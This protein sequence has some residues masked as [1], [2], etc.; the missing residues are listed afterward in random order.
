MTMMIRVS[1]IT[2]ALGLGLSATAL[3]D[4][5]GDVF[6]AKCAS[7]H[8]P[9]GAADSAMGK[10]MKLRD[11]GSAEVQKQSDA[12]LTAIVAK[13]KKPMPGYEGKLTNDQI[14]DVVKYVRS[15]KK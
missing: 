1:L 11:L 12:E 2:L 5:G 15:L 9:T 6:K 14:N 13:G 10:S 7:C 8:G 4:A 3:A